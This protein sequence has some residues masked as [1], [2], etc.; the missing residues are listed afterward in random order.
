LTDLL[1]E[2][3]RLCRFPS[4]GCQAW[5]SSKASPVAG[6]FGR[7]SRYPSRRLRRSHLVLRSA[8][9]ADFPSAAFFS[10][11]PYPVTPPTQGSLS[12]LSDSPDPLSFSCRFV[13]SDRSFCD[14]NEF[15]NLRCWC[16]LVRNSPPERRPVT[17]F[18]FAGFSL[19]R[20]LLPLSSVYFLYCLRYLNFQEVGT[21][22]VRILF[23]NAGAA[24]PRRFFTFPQR[25]S[26][27]SKTP[28]FLVKCPLSSRKP[29]GERRSR[30]PA[31]A[32]LDP[33]VSS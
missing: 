12:S 30:K 11:V 21:A 1:S 29:F 17:P 26:K 24:R 25:F 7:R 27:S 31:D 3:P 10:V 33:R 23:C 4:L 14:W 22:T 13:P 18:P 8:F 9:F 2:L 19:P 28:L 6:F 15:M 5:R 16:H 32:A 20:P